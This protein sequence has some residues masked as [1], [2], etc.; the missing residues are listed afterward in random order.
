MSG[1]SPAS[2]RKKE[3]LL[4]RASGWRAYV[5][6]AQVTAHLAT[7][8]EHD[9]LDPAG[10]HAAGVPVETYYGIR[11][12][13]W[14]RV[15]SRHAARLLDLTV[16][17]AIAGAWPTDLVPA[18]GSRRR[19]HALTAI[20]WTVDHIDAAAGYHLA[21]AIR[22]DGPRTSKR[23]HD[24]MVAVFAALAMTPGPSAKATGRAVG[25]GYHPPLA[26]GVADLDDPAAVPSLPADRA[27]R[28]AAELVA[29]AELVLGEPLHVAAARIGVAEDTL[30]KALERHR[31]DLL[32][33]LREASARW[34]AGGR[35][36]A[37]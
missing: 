34:Q 19:Q 20:G 11:T 37:S 18:L 23:H 29:E 15:E 33:R 2:R 12:G 3:Y 30:V 36:A 1:I 31:P 5:D 32:R 8:R 9:V 4:R 14:A 7:L 10:A 35:R 25:L 17:S 27:R 22:R 13:K 28:P 16:P 21:S 26:W 24:A 6:P